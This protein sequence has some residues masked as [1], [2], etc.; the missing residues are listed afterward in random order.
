MLVTKN[1]GSWEGNASLLTVFSGPGTVHTVL[2]IPPGILEVDVNISI[3][4]MRKSELRETK[5][6]ANI[7][8][9]VSGRARI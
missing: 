6:F 5:A 3:L 7:T 4:Q 1:E 9:P 8:Q 2:L